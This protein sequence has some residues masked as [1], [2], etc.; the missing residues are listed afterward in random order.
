MTPE[1]IARLVARWVRFYTRELPAPIAQRRIN[2]I[3]ADL[4]DH[5]A[6]ERGQGTSDWRIALSILSR[7]IRGVA[8]DV[9]WSDQHAHANLSPREALRR[10]RT[11]YRSAVAAALVT[12]L[13]LLFGMGA[14]GIN[15]EDGDPVDRLYFGV[16]AL[17]IVG[18]V[19]ARSRSDGM[20]LVLLAMA[21]ATAMVAVV[22]LI[23]GK[24]QAAH[25]SVFEILGLNGM[26]AGLFV[27]S[28]WLFWRAARRQPPPDT[29]P[30]A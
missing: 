1:R 20:A 4:H 19:I 23:A 25:N 11:A 22:A 21:L 16:L 14:L 13:F 27:G 29:G 3:D 9:S 17:G 6:H 15:G 12:A 10:H 26:Y 8:A 7:M 5:I 28:A 2:E 18:S 30:E 24:H